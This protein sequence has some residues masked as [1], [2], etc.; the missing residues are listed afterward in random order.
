MQ[1]TRTSALTG[2]TRTLEVNCTQDQ[3]SRFE[4]GQGLAQNIFPDLSADDREF[5]MTGISKEEWDRSIPDE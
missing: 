4:N 2:V 5:I 1:V 3:L